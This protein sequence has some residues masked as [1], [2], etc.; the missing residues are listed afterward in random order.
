MGKNFFLPTETG[1]FGDFLPE[2][3]EKNIGST[4]TTPD[5]AA[6]PR[7]TSIEHGLGSG[8]HIKYLKTCYE[9]TLGD[10]RSD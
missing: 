9:A 4:H 8:E 1:S 10:P 7:E 5:I 3:R 2:R 6:T